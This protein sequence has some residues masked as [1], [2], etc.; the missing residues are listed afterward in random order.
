MF[1]K[2]KNKIIKWW[3]WWILIAYEQFGQDL[4]VLQLLIKT[5]K[6]VFTLILAVLVTFFR[7]RK[8]RNYLFRNKNKEKASKRSIQFNQ[9]TKLINYF[10]FFF[11]A[12]TRSSKDLQSTNRP[13][14]KC[15]V[16]LIVQV[17]ANSL[18]CLFLFQT[19]EFKQFFFF[20]F[21]HFEVLGFG[22]KWAG[23]M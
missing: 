17:N 8:K 7:K 9:L 3:W 19:I 14:L 10:S 20:F 2:P 18:E 11:I 4:F 1:G 21:F 13:Q 23:T 5:S 6:S 12:T 16:W 15:I 22:S